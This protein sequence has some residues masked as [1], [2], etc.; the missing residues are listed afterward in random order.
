MGRG[1]ANMYDT[2]HKRIG[3]R[4]VLSVWKSKGQ[5]H[6]L[7]GCC[8]T[9]WKRIDMAEA[10]ALAFLESLRRRILTAYGDHGYGDYW[11]NHMKACIAGCAPSQVAKWAKNLG[12][13]V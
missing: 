1:T 11:H 10:E 5:W 3:K 6:R 8:W 9:G 13:P 2:N 12:V 7:G 4:P